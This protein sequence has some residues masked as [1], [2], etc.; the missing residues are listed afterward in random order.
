MSKDNRPVIPLRTR[1]RTHA[2]TLSAASRW[3]DHVVER[4]EQGHLKFDSGQLKDML[5]LSRELNAM[6]QQE[7]HKRWMGDD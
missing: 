7:H 2:Q 6:V 1:G 4:A 3:L 5:D